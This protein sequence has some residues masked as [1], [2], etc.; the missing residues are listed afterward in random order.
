M[1]LVAEATSP[2]WRTGERASS[3]RITLTAAFAICNV[4]ELL[5]LLPLAR[6]DL[7][8]LAVIDA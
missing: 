4:C 6:R 2:W 1:E 7:H 3:A 8:A 5:E